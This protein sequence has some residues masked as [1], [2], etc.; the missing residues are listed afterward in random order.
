MAVGVAVAGDP[1]PPE[2]MPVAVPEIIGGMLL[3]ETMGV[4]RVLEVM[5]GP[6]A[7][8]WECEAPVVVCM[9][10]DDIILVLVLVEAGKWAVRW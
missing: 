9:L 1:D 5:T 3:P 7:I 2:G 6:G 8:V 4:G 10:T